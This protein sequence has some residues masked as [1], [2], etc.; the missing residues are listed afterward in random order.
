VSSAKK[1]FSANGDC[2][3]DANFNAVV[4]GAGYVHKPRQFPMYYLHYGDTD[5]TTVY[6]ILLTLYGFRCFDNARNPGSPSYSDGDSKPITTDYAD[7]RKYQNE[8]LKT[9]MERWNGKGYQFEENDDKTEYQYDQR[10][11]Q[12]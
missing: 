9:A 6:G 1:V 12:A 2:F 3:V 5:G 10:Q 11:A 8:G 7:V 4:G